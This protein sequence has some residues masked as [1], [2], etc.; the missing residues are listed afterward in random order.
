MKRL[1]LILLFSLAVTAFIIAVHQLITIGLA[2]SYWI[3]MLSMILLF[4]YQL[5]KG[6]KD[7]LS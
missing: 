6:K 5:Y 4:L 2:G 7:P 3:F 1:L